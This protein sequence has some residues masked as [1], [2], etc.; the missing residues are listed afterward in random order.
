MQPPPVQQPPVPVPPPPVP[1][2]PPNQEAG[3]E[4]DAAD[5]PN[6][7]DPASKARRARRTSDATLSLRATLAFRFATRTSTPGAGVTAAVGWRDFGFGAS[8]YGA[9][10]TVELGDITLWVPAATA[11]YDLVEWG[12]YYRLRTSVEL[13]AALASGTPKGNATGTTESA[14]HAALHVG[15]VASWPLGKSVDVEGGLALG[16]ASSLRA[17]ENQVDVI[18]MDGLLLGAELG[19]RLR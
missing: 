15:V 9:R 6:R 11:F 4:P 17:Q 19:L 18:G 2:V 10:T 3:D 12:G 13:G 1:P 7:D 8:L 14:F 5:D 16:Y